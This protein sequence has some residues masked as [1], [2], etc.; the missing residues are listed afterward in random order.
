MLYVLLLIFVVIGVRYWEYRK[1]IRYMV[2]LSHNYDV[3]FALE[4]F[5]YLHNT[6]YLECLMLN[7]YPKGCE[8]SV[9]HDVGKNTPTFMESILKP[10]TVSAIY[11]N[12]IVEKFEKYKLI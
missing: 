3:A 11:P 9:I 4:Q 1:F 6:Q 7:T 12:Y 2:K 8:W 10:L 5:D